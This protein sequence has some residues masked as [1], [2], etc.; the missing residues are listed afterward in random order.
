MQEYLHAHMC[1]KRMI[2]LS[3]AD[4]IISVNICVFVRGELWLRVVALSGLVLLVLNLTSWVINVL[5]PTLHSTA[6]HW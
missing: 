6:Q 5:K 2:Q 3:N 1:R 4:Q